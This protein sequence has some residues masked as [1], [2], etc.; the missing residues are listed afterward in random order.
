MK[1][2]I[3]NLLN[4][5][6]EI[7]YILSSRQKIE[8]VII[9]LMIIVGSIL[10]TVGVSMVVPFVQ[11][12]MNPRELMRTPAFQSIA[13]WLGIITDSQ[14]VMFTGFT[15]IG[16]YL[17]K[18]LYLMLMSYKQV[19]FRWKMQSEL[20][21]RMLDVYLNRPYTYFLDTNSSTILRGIT[22]DVNS[23]YTIIESLFLCTSNGL[24]ILMIMTYLLISNVVMGLSV[25]VIGLISFVGISLG[26]RQLLKGVGIKQREAN[27]F[28][29]MY[30]YQ[31]VNGIKEID[32]MQRRSFF[33]DKFKEANEVARKTNTRF[34]SLNS[35][36][37]RLIEAISVC[38]MILVVCVVYGSGNAGSEF[39]SQM[40]VF[41]VAALRILPLIGN[42]V[43]TVNGFVYYWKGVDATYN[44]II[45]A[46]RYGAKKREYTVNKIGSVAEE[47]LA[48]PK[49]ELSIKSICWKY[50]NSDRL[51]INDLSLVIH[52]NESVGI[53][54]ASGAG[55]TTL[56]DIIMG[57]YKPQTGTVEFDGVDIY[58]MP[59]RWSKIIGY[60]PQSVFL[61][62]DTIRANVTFG[63]Y[64]DQVD[65][66]KVW[67]A[68]G[69]A[70]MR[71]FVEGLPNGINTRVGE[72]GVKFS[73][74]QKQRIAIAR[75]LYY[76]PDILVLDEATSALD[77]ETEKAVMESIDSLL[78]KKTLIIIAHRLSTIQNCDSVY[79]ITDGKA[80]KR[81]NV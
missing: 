71:E 54:G 3:K 22:D 59:G 13:G 23:L 58:A 65:D 17:I 33:I 66:E 45:E 81:D 25:C 53:I 50:P 16:I 55:K 36:P 61:T 41:V 14:I 57:L 24:T 78:G 49:G 11:S 43:G 20:S 9:L 79:E 75:A 15:L 31:A 10:D 6:R 63:L 5:L 8:C 32:V 62:D 77:N 52:R 56:S 37:P 67:E 48:F 46:E 27:G 73:G 70:Q 12:L 28:Q 64:E 7:R 44:N 30:A 1:N 34:N 39:V 35:F 19:S 4:I 60:V 2:D 68:L 72:R 80:I 29:R 40:A 51:V 76:N 21:E 47:N 26:F 74:G 18:N 42:M 69:L 38:G